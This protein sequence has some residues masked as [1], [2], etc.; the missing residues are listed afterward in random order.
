V[1]SSMGASFPPSPQPLRAELAERPELVTALQVL[2]AGHAE[3]LRSRAQFRDGVECHRELVHTTADYEVWMLSWLPGQI[4][5]IHDHGGALNVT[6]VLS[7]MVLEERFVRTTGCMVR[8]TWTVSRVA[9]EI[10]TLDASVI[11]R[12]RPLGRAVTLHL[13]APVCRDG[14]IFELAGSAASL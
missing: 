5:P 3:A 4:T 12:V 1:Q 9:G 13:C 11:H 2:I 8:P 14:Q 6:A 10:D 7:G